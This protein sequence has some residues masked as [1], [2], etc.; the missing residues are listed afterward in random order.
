MYLGRQEL[1]QHW[2]QGGLQMARDT[3]D[4][5]LEAGLLGGLGSLA[6]A[7]GEP[8]QAN[9]HYRDSLA[10]YT[11]LDDRRGQAVAHNNLGI[12][13]GELGEIAAARVHLEAALVLHRAANSRIALANG[14]MSL[15]ELEQLAAQPERAQALFESSLD[16][17]AAQGDDWSAA[18]ARDGLG[19]CALDRGD[20]AAARRHFEQA[21]AV[22]RGLGDKGA[23]GDQ[24]DHL[25][26]VAH[27]E[28]RP[29][30]A[31]ALAAESAALRLTLNNPRAL[32]ASFQTL[33]E[34]QASGHPERAARLFGGM[35]AQLAR[36]GVVGSAARRQRVQALR[37]ELTA[38][39]G[40]ARFESLATEGAA[41]DPALLAGL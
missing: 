30:D 33:A 27:L 16:I 15:G 3:G 24:L 14:L 7:R 6:N 19:K 8:Q 9:Q 1:A 4:G 2:L 12:T 5:G 28:A 26:Q 32:A 37:D 39:L 29:D 11:R 40:G 38:R 13:L 35:Q 21:L 41:C 25:A 22:L 23:I 20:L 17:F 31:G 18:Y 10:L 34:L 36:S